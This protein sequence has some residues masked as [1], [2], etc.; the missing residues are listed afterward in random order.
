VDG[1]RCG[2]APEQD[3]DPD[4]KVDESDKPQSLIDGPVLRLQ[5]HLDIESCRAVQID[6]L[7]HGP[8]DGIGRMRPD[9]AVKHLATQRGNAW[10]RAIV[11]T[12]KNV[13]GPDSCTV[14]RRTRRHPFRFQAAVG[15]DPPNAIR[16]DVEPV[17]VLEVHCGQHTDRYGR[18][19]EH[20]GQDPGLGSV[21][22]ETW[23]YISTSVTKPI[24]SLN[25]LMN[26]Q[27]APIP[28]ENHN[29]FRNSHY[30]GQWYLASVILYCSRE[31]KVYV[32]ACLNFLSHQEIIQRICNFIKKP[33]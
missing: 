32:N 1:F 33:F 18:Q 13:A 4:A 20:D 10:G 26:G 6:R 31:Q 25:A 15:L 8:E 28:T 29:L 14:P 17:F 9:S 23:H 19:S 2:P 30:K 7:R 3:I 12:D 16:W 21:F 27:V 5:N 22:H 11:H 24:S